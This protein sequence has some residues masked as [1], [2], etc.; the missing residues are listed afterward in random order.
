MTENV[1][2]QRAELDGQIMWTGCY[3]VLHNMTRGIN[4]VTFY[5]SVESAEQAHRWAPATVLSC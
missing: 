2:L 4:S 1:W 5:C 3:I